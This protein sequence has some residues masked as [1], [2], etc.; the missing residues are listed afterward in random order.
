MANSADV[1][2]TAKLFD[3]PTTFADVFS[4]ERDQI[5]RSRRLRGNHIPVVRPS[6]SDPA[7]DSNTLVG[8]AFSGG[9]IRSATFNLGILQ[10]LARHQLLRKFDY[11]STVSG[12]GYVGSWL[13]A[14]TKR[15]LQSVPGSDFATVEKSLVPEKY[16]PGE[17]HERSFLHWLR[18]YSNYLTPHSGLFSGDTWAMVGTWIRNCLLNQ[19]I[20]ALLFL[21]FFVASEA[22][23]LTLV[24]AYGWVQFVL[25]LGGAL[26]LFA[27]VR[28]GIN[29]VQ[30][31]PVQ[32]SKSWFQ[33]VQIRL[34]IVTP[35][36]GAAL[37]VNSALWQL[38][39]IG[40]RRMQ[41]G[42][43][44]MVV[45]RLPLLYWALGGAAFYFV[46]WALAICLVRL[47]VPQHFE[48]KVHHGALLL[49][50]LGAGAIAGC[51]MR[52]YVVML[53]YLKVGAGVHWAV[54]S[55]GP[56]AV[57]LVMLCCG[58]FHQGLTGRGSR[59]LVREWWA[60]LGG[61]LAVSSLSILFVAALCVYGPLLVLFTWLKL[62][63]WSLVPALAWALHNYVGVKAASSAATNGKAGKPK[64]AQSDQGGGLLNKIRS[65]FSSPRAL[66]LLARAA[67]YVFATG[68]LLLLSTAVH[69]GAGLAF[70]P[71][72]TRTLWQVGAPTP[73]VTSTSQAAAGAAPGTLN[74]NLYWKV[75][76]GNGTSRKI[77]L[78]WMFGT[79]V[80]LLGFC[81]LLSWR[82]DINDFSLHH[83]YRNRL[84]RCYL[85]AS[86]PMRHPHPFTGFDEKDDIPLKEFSGD[87]PGP[88]P[89]INAALNITSG[90]ELGYAT[91]R[92]KSFVFT[93]QYCGYESTMV[94]T[95]QSWF[96]RT[97]PGGET[98][99]ESYSSTAL[100]RS[101]NTVGQ[102][103]PKDGI[104]LGTAMAISGAAA[105]P[106]MGYYTSAATGLFMTLFDVRLGWW[107]GNPA[108]SKKWAS[109]GPG[110]GLTYL[111]SE[112][113]AQSDQSKSFVY[114]SDGGHFEN[115]AVYE[116][117]RRRCKL[118]VACDADCDDGY[119]FQN[120][121]DL[122]EKARTDLGAEIVV[123]FDLIRPADGSRESEQNFVVGDIFY[124]PQNPAERGRFIYVKT[125]MPK[126]PASSEDQRWRHHQNLLPDDVWQ[127]FKKHET[128]PHQSTADQWFDELQFESYRAL[129]EFI[130]NQA[131]ADIQAEVDEALG[132]AASAAGQHG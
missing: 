110:L 6:K 42:A 31:P 1:D 17:R 37:L 34:T 15:Y 8:L 97:N 51:L 10:A 83:F 117:L 77:L 45:Y 105:S 63:S 99:K 50:S 41:T 28:M 72:E 90:G 130:G 46:V 20:L 88:Y 30:P 54:T 35:F 89:L 3:S 116:L 74:R 18:L 104:K 82:V 19:T 123:N 103:Y 109:P 78:P 48:K 113:V 40:H 55:M 49:S 112:L 9:G 122:I 129:G 52:E 124:D 94:G 39:V 25:G 132:G 33:R 98:F 65:L 11:L 23:L 131:A 81:L 43:S 119:Q 4:Q 115:L 29:V 21:S 58:T 101:K 106:N 80:L 108:I 125:S 70:N 62:R 95:E 61:Y 126:A 66:D 24:R 64:A 47:F 16:S 59:D 38:V 120:L 102:I 14:L 127:Y 67:P 44:G 107:M 128:F 32:E 5:Q 26:M 100:G 71:S 86:N 60:R 114:L 79:A 76:Q 69:I 92:A 75:L 56:A 121:L 12:G 22:V 7:K 13:A 2:A 53:A 27:A 91:R 87:Y 118:I 93:P 84:V 36:L 111:L 96:E 57:M 73:A 85:G 68:L